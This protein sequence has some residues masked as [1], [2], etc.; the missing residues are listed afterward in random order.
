L[1]YIPM[2]KKMFPTAKFIHIIRDIRDVCLSARKAWNRNIYYSAQRWSQSLDRA[3]KDAAL[4]A[5]DDYMEI[6]YETLIHE[7]G[8]TLKQA[9]RFLGIPYETHMAI[10]KKPSEDEG[11]A[12]GKAFIMQGN[13]GKWKTRLTPRQLARLESLCAPLLTDLG[14]PLSQPFTG[15]TKRMNPIRMYYY[16]FQELLYIFR[17]QMKRK[18]VGAAAKTIF[19]KIKFRISRRF[20]H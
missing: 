12:R 16:Y 10:L 19:R 1:L 17:M 4:H 20:K 8:E 9:C 6:K 11:D 18:S 3:R 5:P 2:L 14:Y 15:R 13:T 7:P